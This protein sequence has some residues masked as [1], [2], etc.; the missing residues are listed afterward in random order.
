MAKINIPDRQV[1][2]NERALVA[3]DDGTQRLGL[4]MQAA[5]AQIKQA[6]DEYDAKAR[7]IEV[8]NQVSTRV[9]AYKKEVDD[10]INNRR[11]DQNGWKTIHED[12]KKKI[13]EL[14]KKYGS[15]EN[16]NEI[17]RLLKQNMDNEDLNAHSKINTIKRQQEVSAQTTTVK[18]N[19]DKMRLMAT[20]MPAKDLAAY[21]AKAKQYLAG[22]AEAGLFTKDAAQ[23]T[24]R[25]FQSAVQDN[26][27]LRMIQN[28][29]GRALDFLQQN[30]K[31]PGIEPGR[32]IQL[33]NMAKSRHSQGKAV[34]DAKNKSLLE[35]NLISIEKTGKPVDNIDI[36]AKDYFLNRP[37]GLQQYQ[38]KVRLHTQRYSDK[39]TLESADPKAINKMM[40]EVEVKPGDKDAKNKVLRG[41]YIAQYKKQLETERKNNPYGAAKKYL[42]ALETPDEKEKRQA[43][44]KQNQNL[45]WY[46]Q[47]LTDKQAEI[48][49]REKLKTIQ[50]TVFGRREN[51]ISVMDKQ[52]ALNYVQQYNNMKMVDRPQFFQAM[53]DKY[54]KDYPKAF[55]DMVR[56]GKLPPEANLFNVYTKVPSGI[57]LAPKLANA[58]GMK[59]DD[60]AK[61]N[62]AV[63]SDVRTTIRERIRDAMEPYRST[64]AAADPNDTNLVAMQ[65]FEEAFYKMAIIEYTKTKDKD[66]G[67]NMVK[68]T[69]DG[70]DGGSYKFINTR[71]TMVTGH[72]K[73]HGTATTVS[74]IRANVRLPNTQDV[75]QVQLQNKMRDMSTK[76][77]FLKNVVPTTDRMGYK[78]DFSKDDKTIFWRD[79]KHSGQWV[80]KADD[81]GVKLVDERGHPVRYKNK[82]GE[83]VP[84]EIDFK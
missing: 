69:F 1:G 32:H 46:E 52:K 62:K 29:P 78:K 21:M 10:W 11:A 68:Q 23:Q 80:T 17:N 33:E 16:D 66:A 43:L 45:P 82:K 6:Q 19:L 18:N 36:I 77:F 63:D 71:L 53:R 9:L 12:Y 61:I 42:Q 84:V 5:G 72:S 7:K 35:S 31:I 67:A 57:L 4:Q 24:W 51:Q 64:V 28:D 34:L 27:I 81:T 15:V 37:G 22:Q 74:T 13:A 14:R 41:Q 44:E 8:N 49:K 58:L 56:L 3:P 2:I 30:K 59:R 55:R 60:F 48:D 47:G 20:D 40:A 76:D 25:K 54:G 39:K 26:R 75:D 65:R 83:I 50:K 38:E 70:D 73:V 79:I